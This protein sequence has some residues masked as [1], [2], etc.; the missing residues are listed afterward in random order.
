M[1]KLLLISASTHVQSNSTILAKTVLSGLNY[2]EIKLNNVKI[3]D[4][5]DFRFSPSWPRQNDDYYQIIERLK[6]TDIIVFSTPIYW[7]GIAAILKRLVE[8]WSESL[9]TD[10]D[11][12]QTMQGKQIILII[13]GGDEPVVKGQ[14]IIDQFNYICEFLGMKLVASVIGEANRPGTIH[15]DLNALAEAR[16]INRILK[17]QL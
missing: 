3:F 1:K 11:F 10:V 4:V 14:I 16:N 5:N 15:K 17:S 8:R 12:R 6:G 2:Q 13:V 7:Y 9:K